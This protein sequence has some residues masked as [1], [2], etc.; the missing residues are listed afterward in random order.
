MPIRWLF[1]SVLET[2]DSFFH[3]DLE[4]P[5]AVKPIYNQQTGVISYETNPMPMH[6]FFLENPRKITPIPQI[7]YWS[8]T[9]CWS[10][11]KEKGPIE[12]RKKDRP[13]FLTLQRKISLL[14]NG[15]CLNKCEQLTNP[16]TTPGHLSHEKKTASL[17]IILV[18]LWGSLYWFVIIPI[19]LIS[20]IPYMP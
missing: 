15:G 1:W 13:H 9:F 4:H 3:V 5:G 7:C 2:W 20:I 17:S 19:K 8:Y 10:P 12:W 6:S 14:L 16:A 11:Q 18:G